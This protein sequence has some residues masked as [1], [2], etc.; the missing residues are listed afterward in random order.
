VTGKVI[1]D[2]DILSEYLKGHNTAVASRAAG[3][4]NAHDMFTFTSVTVF[5]MVYGLELKGASLQPNEESDGLAE[6][7]RRDYSH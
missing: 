2:T 3:Y 5:E 6:V 1:L 4:I 7:E